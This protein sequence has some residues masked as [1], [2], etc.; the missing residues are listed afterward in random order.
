[1]KFLCDVH[2]SYK[3]AKMLVSLGFDAI[4]VNEILNKS[5]TKDSDLSKY[6][7]Q[8]NFVIISK[9]ADFRD[10]YFVKRTPKK[11]IRVMLGNISNHELLRIFRENMDTIVGLDS[12]TNFLLEIDKNKI[13]LTEL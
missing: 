7:D 8:N 5:E 3:L 6:A 11:L 2:I 13:Q 9:D 10:T 4:H 12:K 1:M